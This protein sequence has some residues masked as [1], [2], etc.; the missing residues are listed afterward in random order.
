MKA[1]ADAMGHSVGQQRAYVKRDSEAEQKFDDAPA[2][3]TGK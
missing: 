2:E 3:I 1:D